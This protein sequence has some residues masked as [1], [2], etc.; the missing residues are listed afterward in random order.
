[1]IQPYKVQLKIKIIINNASS[2]L[3]SSQ[4]LVLEHSIN[5]VKIWKKSRRGAYERTIEK[6]HLL[7][8]TF[9][10]FMQISVMT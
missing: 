9:K 10:K 2:V 5:D 3:F 8:K 4:R 7:P 1:M 6:Q